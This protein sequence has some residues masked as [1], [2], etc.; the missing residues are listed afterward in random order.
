MV[1]GKPVEQWGI[2]DFTSLGPYKYKL[3]GNEFLQK[4]IDKYKKLGIYMQEPI[5]YEE[6]SMRILASYDLLSELLEK[7][8]N[9]FKYRQGHLQFL[10]C[11][12]ASKSPG[13]KYLKWISE[14]KLGIVTQCCLSNSANEGEDKF[15]TNLALKINAKLGGS[16]VELN[17]WLPYFEGEG[18]VMFL[19][20]DVNHPGSRDT[21]SPSIAAVVATVN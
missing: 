15:Y 11:V 18:H 4:L 13:Y 1:E 6:S 5:V 21:S 12:M 8:N 10:L 3:R 19:G 2:L 17:N 7:V 14:T 20:A 9:F 16:N